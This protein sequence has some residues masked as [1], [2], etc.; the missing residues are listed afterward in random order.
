MEIE[1]IP[2]RNGKEKTKAVNE[3]HVKA[4]FVVWP[5]RFSYSSYVLYRRV[6]CTFLSHF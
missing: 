2:E 3:V 1:L 4:L 6:G 5:F